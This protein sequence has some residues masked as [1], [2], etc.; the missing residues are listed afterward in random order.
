M[1]VIHKI[2]T[3]PYLSQQERRR[4]E[5]INQL[6]NQSG[7]A[8]TT[9]EKD[10]GIDP[11]DTRW[12]PGVL[13]RYGAKADD[14]TDCIEAFNAAIAQARL[15]GGSPVRAG[16]AGVYRVSAQI[17]I[18]EGVS[19]WGHS[20]HG[21]GSSGS[22][23][24]YSSIR[25]VGGDFVDVIKTNSATDDDSISIRYWRVLGGTFRA[26]TARYGFYAEAFHRG[27]ELVGNIFRDCY[28]TVRINSGYYSTVRDNV[29]G[30]VTPA[31]TAGAATDAEFA[32][33]YTANSASL[34]LAEMNGSDCSG[35][36]LSIMVSEN[37][38]AAKPIQA[39]YVSGQDVDCRRWAIEST[40]VDYSTFTPRMDYLIK[41]EGYSDFSGLYVEA[42]NSDLYTFF[43]F[44]EGFFKLENFSVF[45]ADC[46]TMFRNQALG[47]IHLKNGVIYDTDTDNAWFCSSTGKGAGGDVQ[48][49][50]VRWFSG[51]RIADTTYNADTANVYDTDADTYVNGAQDG[52]DLRFH[53]RYR[54]FPRKVTGLTVSSS[55]DAGGEFIDIQSGVL[56]SEDGAYRNCKWRTGNAT[57]N[58]MA[59]QRLRPETNSATYRV[60]VGRLGNIHLRSSTGAFTDSRGDWISTFTTGASGTVGGLTDNPRLS[61]R[62]TYIPGT[63]IVQISGTG[64]PESSVSAPVGSVYHRDDGGASTSFYVKES[65]TG[66]TGWIAK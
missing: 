25:Y 15:S 30:L 24:V 55:S 40:G 37:N 29:M 53:G 17:I 22:E 7:F 66:N 3:S 11:I 27:C 34:Y 54:N 26:G 43:N 61:L 56:L 16:E 39:V 2:P 31:Q 46:A 60:Y 45:N 9:A 38:T 50:D 62:G 41:N 20:P 36:K 19:M 6:I 33:V 52:T 48:A 44:G 51:N 4:T 12:P 18:Y 57:N 14:A 32:Q 58:N 10:S 23:E 49:N 21:S 63:D 1:T 28:G 5:A 47:D 65:G 35:N 8:K 13:E 42:C 59:V 64:T